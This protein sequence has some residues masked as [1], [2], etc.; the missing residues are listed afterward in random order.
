MGAGQKA[1]KQLVGIART[2]KMPGKNP[3]ARILR[4]LLVSNCDLFVLGPG[5]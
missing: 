2:T 5:Y 4:D 3:G 1:P